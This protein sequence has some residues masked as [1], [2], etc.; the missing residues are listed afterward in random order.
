VPHLHCA[1]IGGLAAALAVPVAACLEN[2]PRPS[3]TVASVT[4]TPE[5]S[6]IVQGD[7]RTLVATARDATHRVLPDVLLGWSSSDPN[8]ATVDGTGLVGGLFPGAASILATTDHVSGSARVTVVPRFALLRISPPGATLVP[9][10]ALAFTADGVDSAG[11]PIARRAPAWSSSDTAVVRTTADGGVVAFREG[12]AWL[13]ARDGALSDSVRVR[14]TTVRFTAVS[15]GPSQN[16]CAT[17]PQGAFCWGYEGFAG[18]HGVGAPIG[19]ASAPVAV[20]GGERFVMVRAGD[21]FTCGLTSEGAPYCWGSGAFGRLGDGTTDSVRATPAPVAGGLILRALSVGRRHACGLAASGVAWCWGGNTRGALGV[22]LTIEQSAVPVAVSTEQ[23]FATVEA[24]YQH[25]CGLAPD[26]VAWCWGRGSE[27]GDSVAV[28]RAEPAPV[29]GGH[30]FRSLSVGW[31]HTCGVATDGLVYCWGRNPTGEIGRWTDPT[32]TMPV[33]VDGGPALQSV[34]AG[35]YTTCG[36]TADGSAYC[37]GSNFGG[38]LGTGDTIGGPLPRPVSGGLHFTALSAGYAHTCGISTDAL[39]YC[40]GA[41]LEGMLGDGVDTGTVRGPVLVAGQ[42]PPT[43][44]RNR[45]R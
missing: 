25:T 21:G 10:G 29:Y 30:R 20:L 8:V 36:L 38:Q 26:G 41:G 1:G 4:I 40:W 16:T 33:P 35:F 2:I 24:G 31:T 22:P 14:V 3:G 5:S 17:G 34:T 7:T 13:L 11:V 28:M 44:A 27:L 12:A 6:Q 19:G 42:R 45:L 37:W 9:G 32:V 23:P 15:A 39:L 43:P 18:S